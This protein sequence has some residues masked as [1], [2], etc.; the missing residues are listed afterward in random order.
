M[1][2]VVREIVGENHYRWLI[3]L[4]AGTESKGEFIGLLI[5]QRARNHRPASTGDTSLVCTSSLPVPGRS[6]KTG[7]SRSFSSKE[8]SASRLMTKAPSPS[9]SS[10][11]N[12]TIF[13]V[14]ACHVK[15]EVIGD[16]SIIRHIIV[17]HGKI[18]RFSVFQTNH[19][20]RHRGLRDL[21]RIIHHPVKAPH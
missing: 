10:T 17:A 19:V 7:E 5:Q 2:L 3:G 6:P 9:E 15:H 13:G 1:E 14:G 11:S 8:G 20:V 21:N 4:Q 12:R 16:G 18:D